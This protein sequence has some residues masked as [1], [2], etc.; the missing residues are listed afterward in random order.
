MSRVRRGAE[1][2]SVAVAAAVGAGVFV[3]VYLIGAFMFG[4]GS[5]ALDAHKTAGFIVH[6]LELAV[7]VAAL[8]AWLPRT[9]L[10]LSFALAVIGTAQIALV[11]S[12][13]W[14]GALHPL[15]ALVVLA[16]AVAL[17]ARWTARRAALPSA[18]GV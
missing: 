9:D 13:E 16:L 18:G 2:V 7:F 14:V 4:A 3:Q 11:D 10:A 5:G 6:S 1:L 15:F 12:T 8:V 17:I